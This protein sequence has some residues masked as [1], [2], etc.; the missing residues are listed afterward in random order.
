MP[1]L[2]IILYS[3]KLGREC[4]KALRATFEIKQN[5]INF[6]DLIKHLDVSNFNYNSQPYCL[7][8]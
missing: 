1:M 4:W 6:C 5:S 7:T 2:Y 3:R 8:Y